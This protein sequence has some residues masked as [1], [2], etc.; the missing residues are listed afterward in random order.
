MSNAGRS[1][2]P[3]HGKRDPT[4]T[5]LC[6]HHQEDVILI[7]PHGML[8]GGGGTRAFALELRRSLEARP[9]AIIVDFTATGHIDSSTIGV[10]QA[11][12]RRGAERG[13]ELLICNLNR[14]ILRTITVVKLSGILHIFETRAQC[15]E[16][17]RRS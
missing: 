5:K 16:R 4:V 13:V 1:R 3:E 11:T 2:Q 9:R 12:H 14:R 15:L 10:L 6:V 17:V 7:T 8:M